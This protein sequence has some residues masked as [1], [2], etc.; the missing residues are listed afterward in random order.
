M[1]TGETY[2]I[3]VLEDFLKVPESRRE[4]CFSEFRRA[5]PRFEQMVKAGLCLIS[6][7]WT[8][9]GEEGLRGLTINGEHFDVR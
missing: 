9:D 6:F 3:R 5:L 7:K 4:A 8:D 2:E 1:I